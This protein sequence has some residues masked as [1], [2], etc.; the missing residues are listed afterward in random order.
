MDFD[1]ENLQKEDLQK[2]SDINQIKHNNIIS[3]FKIIKKKNEKIRTLFSNIFNR[4]LNSDSFFFHLLLITL[5]DERIKK[6]KISKIYI[7]NKSL[8][9]VI[10]SKY[11]NIEISIKKKKNSFLIIKNFFF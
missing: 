6:K 11:P 10:K 2:L 3:L 7:N 8:G 9:R 1:L 5:I 4:E